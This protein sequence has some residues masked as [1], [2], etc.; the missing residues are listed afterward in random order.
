MFSHLM[1]VTQDQQVLDYS[2]VFY[3]VTMPIQSDSKLKKGGNIRNIA[4]ADPGGFTGP[5]PDPLTFTKSRFLLLITLLNCNNCY[6]GPILALA[7]PSADSD[8][9]QLIFS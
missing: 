3:I 6:P 5:Q 4:V 8:T 7:K 2:N 1:L 9:A